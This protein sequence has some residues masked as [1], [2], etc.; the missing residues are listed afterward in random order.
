MDISPLE[1][2]IQAFLE[3]EIPLDWNN[4]DK[5]TIERRRMFWSNNVALDGPTMPR[6]QVCI[7]EIWVELLLKAPADITKKQSHELGAMLRH[8]GWKPSNKS[9]KAGPYG[10]Q[11]VFEL[12]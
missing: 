5:W 11:K 9:C 4:P 3:R 7:A 6:K 1:G 12:V 2:S 10:S 8:I